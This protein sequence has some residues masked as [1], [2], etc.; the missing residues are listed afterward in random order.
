VNPSPAWWIA[1]KGIDSFWP[2]LLA[3]AQSLSPRRCHGCPT[4]DTMS[5]ITFERKT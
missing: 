1:G 2:W 5:R 4:F 3:Q